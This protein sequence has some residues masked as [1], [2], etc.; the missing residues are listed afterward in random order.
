MFNAYRL[1]WNI[2]AA[3][4][5]ELLN[6]DKYIDSLPAGLNFSIHVNILSDTNLCTRKNSNP[7]V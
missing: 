3:S 4:V 6:L 1:K 2:S 5:A 7:P